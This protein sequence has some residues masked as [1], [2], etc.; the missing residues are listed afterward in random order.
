MRKKS[1]D[2]RLSLHDLVYHKLIIITAFI[3]IVFANDLMGNL[4]PCYLRRA[5]DKDL[6]TRHLLVIAFVFFTSTLNNFNARL[7][8]LLV[9]SILG[10]MLFLI[11]LKTD[12]TFG[13]LGLGLTLILIIIKGL[14]ANHSAVR[15]NEQGQKVVVLKKDRDYSNIEMFFL[16]IIK[17]YPNIELHITYIIIGV[18]LVGF[19]MYLRRKKLQ[20]K[21]AFSFYVFIFTTKSEKCAIANNFY[22]NTSFID[23]FKLIKHIFD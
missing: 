22:N 23:R 2:Q 15:I 5:I 21:E 6:H 12:P 17:Y 10:Y 1:E 14:S 20:F 13:F 8:T 7:D 3:Y 18:W 19:L 11:S 9:V 4:L 16:N